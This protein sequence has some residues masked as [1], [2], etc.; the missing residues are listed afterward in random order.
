MPSASVK[1]S[2]APG[3]GRSLRR[4]R[5]D[6]CGQPALV[7]S[8]MSVASATQAPSRICPSASM[9]GIQHWAGIWFT[10]AWIPMLTANPNENPTP[11]SRQAAANPWVAPAESDRAN[12]L[13]ESG[14]SGSPGRGRARSGSAASAMSS[15]A[16]WSAAVFDPAFPARSNPASASPPATSGRSRKHSSG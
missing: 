4:I 15:T 3:C 7:G 13:G 16:T 10:I 12:S 1:V 6:P 14:L 5:R 11:R 9:A 8:V 2:W